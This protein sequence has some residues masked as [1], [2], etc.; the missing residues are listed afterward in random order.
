MNSETRILIVDDEQ[1]VRESLK[2]WF[3]EDG[4]K[5][6]VS[7]DAFNVLE[8][9]KPDKWDIMLVDIKMPKMSGLELLEKVKAVDQECVVIIITAYASVPTA[10]QALKNGAFDYVT[11]PIDPDE[12]SHL[13]EKAIKHKNLQRENIALKARIDEMLN[14]EDLVGES[15]EM[16]KVFEFIQIVAPQDTTVM[17]RGESGTGKELIARAIHI[18]S[19]RKYYP[20][21]PVNCGAFAETLLESELFGHEKG[22]FTGAQYKRK[23]KIEM[24]DGGT[25]FLDEVGSLSPKMQIELLRVIES[26]QF[27]RVGG[28]ELVKVNFR[29]ISATNEPLEKLVEEGRFREDLYYRLN[30]FVI[31]VP[32]LRERRSDIP[33]L[34][35]FFVHK[36]SRLMNK[37][38]KNISKEAMEVLFNYNW[39]GNV[40]E[41]ENAIERAMVVGT[42]PEI[43]V[44]NLPFKIENTKGMSDSL[45]D[46]EKLHIKKVLIKHNWNVTRAAAA[47]E[48]DRVTL[49]NKIKKYDFR[50]D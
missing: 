10:V 4:Y 49:Y 28:N 9:L 11:K 17:I 6:D 19:P 48:I 29:L 41:L 18:N 8:I 26:K 20:I 14:L 21:I 36:F 34:A 15:P 22:A 47:L 33:V 43:Q 5:V 25:L 27:H 39:P 44:D 42:L 3:E 16:K 40:R 32:P 23:G 24:A 1:V 45:S 46:I 37:P 35:K 7:E 31:Y 2:H 13:I 30:V 50:K 38:I 12:L